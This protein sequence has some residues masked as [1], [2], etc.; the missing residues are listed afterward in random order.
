MFTLPIIYPYTV[1]HLNYF[2]AIVGR[3]LDDF[4]LDDVGEEVATRREFCTGLLTT[5]TRVTLKVVP[6]DSLETP[7]PCRLDS[8]RGFLPPLFWHD[9]VC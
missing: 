9:R 3:E 5:T 2:N 4:E 1:Q 8:A 6:G 7:S